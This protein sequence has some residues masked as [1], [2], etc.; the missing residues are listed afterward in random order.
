MVYKLSGSI[1]V[2]FLFQIYTTAVFAQSSEFSACDG[3][4]GAASG[5]CRAGVA[6]G[7]NVD[8]SS[9]ACTSIAEQYQQQTGTPPPYAVV[10]I[11][12]IKGDQFSQFTI[13]DIDGRIVSSDFVVIYESRKDPLR[14]GYFLAGNVSVATDGKS[15]TGTVPN[16]PFDG[17]VEVTYLFRVSPLDSNLTSR[18]GDLPDLVFTVTNLDCQPPACGGGI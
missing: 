10:T 6:V 13:T 15:L 18:F 14:D 12:P 1:L 11:S 7:C 8:G 9:D 3:L 17:R 4:Q 2:L 5:I 16:L